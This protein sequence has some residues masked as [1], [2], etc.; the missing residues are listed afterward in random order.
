MCSAGRYAFFSHPAG[1]CPGPSVQRPAG[2]GGP[3]AEKVDRCACLIQLIG[4]L[5]VLDE[6]PGIDVL[7][8]GPGMGAMLVGVADGR[9]REHVVLE[10]ARGGCDGPRTT[11]PSAGAESIDMFILEYL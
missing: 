4:L 9:I 6:G 1:G 5:D 2:S 7:D 11:V 8:E 3:P 10:V